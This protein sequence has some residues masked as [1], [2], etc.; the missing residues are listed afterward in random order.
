[1]TVYVV[2]KPTGCNRHRCH[3]YIKLQILASPSH[4]SFG[5]SASITKIED[6]FVPTTK[7]RT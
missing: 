2:L 7:Y 4:N 6:V 5:S 1:M 3:N